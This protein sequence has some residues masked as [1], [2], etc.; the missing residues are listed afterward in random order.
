MMC[1]GSMGFEIA[2]ERTSDNKDWKWST[3]GSGQG[4]VA[5]HIVAG[6]LSTIMIQNL[7]KSFQIDLS[8]TD[9][10]LF[11][12]NGKDA[13]RMHNNSLDLY[14]WAKNGNLIGA[15]ISLTRTE[16][17]GTTNPDKPLIGL[18]NE[19]DSALSL[20]YKHKEIYK[21]YIEFDKYNILKDEIGKAIRFFS[22]IDFRENSI[23]RAILRSLNDKNYINVS[24]KQIAISCEDKKYY[25][26]LSNNGITF[27]Q[28]NVSILLRDGKIII[29]G[30]VEFT[31]TVTGLP[32]TG[33]GGGG[34]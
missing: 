26:V 28:D 8:G 34:D 6:V 31:G 23:Y 1:I 20:G 10:A 9:G 21:S 32:N 15:L 2:S 19:L 22:D 11:R 29:N 30:P 18:I 5:D 13:L 16:K 4:F 12:N 27:G 7:D 14:N 33:V 3:F 24:D 17:D 25:I